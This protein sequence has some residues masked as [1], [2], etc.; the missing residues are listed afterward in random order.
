[1]TARSNQRSPRNLRGRRIGVLWVAAVGVLAAGCGGPTGAPAASAP[2]GEMPAAAA[3]VFGHV[4]GLGVDPADDRIYVATHDGL[5]RADVNGRLEPSGTTKRDL[6]GFTVAGPGTF[7]SSGHS[8][9]DEQVAN[10]LGLV[11][12]TDA[13]ATWTTLSLAGEVDF[14]ALEI[15]AGTVYGL[16]AG[17]QVLRVSTD[18]GS[19]WQ[20]RAAL[21][22]LD[23]AVDPADPARVL[24]TV[25]G[26]VAAS[27][28]GGR[29]FT[30]PAGPQLAFLS[31]APGGTI[32][33]LGLEGA[34]HV[35]TDRGATWQQLGTV[36]G[37]RPQA[38]TGLTTG[39]VL[40]ATA[41]GIYES[42]DGGH[43]FSSVT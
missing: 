37:G 21:P 3:P 4:H 1:M 24:A 19:S 13:G 22:A 36:P 38:V 27:A 35:S 5:F 42:R 18:G 34:L 2:T 7:L 14:H 23:I 31:W 15:S 11:R 41:G 16:D 28:D 10:P 12:S 26:G 33:G 20:D 8:G 9:S 30:A 6:M 29:T 32:Y 25:R 40:A 43:T 39:R 17:R